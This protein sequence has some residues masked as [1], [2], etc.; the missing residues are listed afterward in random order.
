M[1]LA[2][3]E[4]EKLILD[5]YNQGKTYKQIAQTARVSPRDIKPVLEKAEKE[6]EKELGINT[7]E[8]TNGSTGNQNHTQKKTSISSQAYRLFS[9]GKTLLDVA[10]ELNIKQPEATKY[11]IQY[12][13]LRELHN[14]NLV[15]E[16]IRDNIVHFVQ[17]Y[18]KMNA[19]CIGVEQAIHLTKIANNDLPALEQ[20]YQK[21]KKDV[22]SLESR[23]FEE[24]RTLNDLQDQ[25]AS[26]ERIL[27]WLKTLCQEEEAKI[28]QLESEEI[29]V[30][31]LVKRFKNNNEEYLKIKKIVKQHVAS[32]LFDSKRLL[33]LSL[34]SLMESMRR[35]PQKYSN[36]IYY[37]GSSSVRNIDQ[38]STRYYYHIHGQQPY[39][40]FDNFF[41]EYNSTLLEDAEKLYNKS[42]KEWSEQI[43]TRYSIGNIS[44]QLSKPNRKRQQLH[45]KPFN[46][47]LLPVAISNNQS[48]P[49]KR[50]KRIFVKTEF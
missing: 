47:L 31:R 46:G 42:V 40:S 7:Q 20:K 37:T 39:S 41:E 25:I 30:K 16:E 15:Y 49:F 14:L 29:R 45:H 18:R 23:K 22:Y 5:L 17:Y 12:W 13:K 28:N 2:R 44:S 38:Y 35:D 1:V 19:A 3:Q 9:E 24:H 11:Y 33:H 27:K 8:E 34:S 50:V 6:R 36:L 43:I 21:L 4:K 10:I 32:I 26:S 48:Y